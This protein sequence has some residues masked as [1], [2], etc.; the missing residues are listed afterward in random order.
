MYKKY[1]PHNEQSLDNMLQIK[2]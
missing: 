1:L 2:P